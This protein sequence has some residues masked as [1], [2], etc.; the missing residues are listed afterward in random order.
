VAQG[1]RAGRRV[2]SGTRPALYGASHRARSR[3]LLEVQL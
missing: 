1:G 3:H 2:L